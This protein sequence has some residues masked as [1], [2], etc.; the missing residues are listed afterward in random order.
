VKI[1]VGPAEVSCTAYRT[2]RCAACGSHLDYQERR[3]WQPLATQGR[4]MVIGFVI[5]QAAKWKA[6]PVA[7]ARCPERLVRPA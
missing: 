7:C 6:E 5:E 2:A 3:F 1:I 4:P